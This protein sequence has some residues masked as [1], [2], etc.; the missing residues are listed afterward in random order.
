MLAICPLRWRALSVEVSEKQH[1]RSI[2]TL[3]LLHKLAVALVLPE[4]LPERCLEVGAIVPAHHLT[5]GNR[6]F[7]SMVEGN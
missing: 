3:A 6:C 4:S 2:T 1:T 5:N 7:L